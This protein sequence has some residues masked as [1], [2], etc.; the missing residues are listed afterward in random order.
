MEDTLVGCGYTAWN[1]RRQK[2]RAQKTCFKRM[3]LASKRRMQLASNRKTHM[4][5]SARN[6][7]ERMIK[8]T[9]DLETS[10]EEYQNTRYHALDDNVKQGLGMNGQDNT[11]QRNCKLTSTNRK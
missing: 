6:K 4:A 1:F 9:E 10:P 11:M 7:L 2:S 8:S 5:L 3:Q